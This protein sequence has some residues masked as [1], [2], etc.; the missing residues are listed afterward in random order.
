MENVLNVKNCKLIELTSIHDGYDGILCIAESSKH[1]PFDIKRVY[2]IYNLMNHQD[3]MRGKHAHKKLKQVL[4]CI[5]G[6]CAVELDDGKNKQK[7]ILDQPH[8][9]IYLGNNLWHTMSEFTNNCILL[10]MAS[11]VYDESDYIRDY[12]EFLNHISLS[13]AAV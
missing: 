6:S 1:I 4:F 8:Q 3:V 9:G 12:Q 2:Y 13:P 10:V 7:I 5:S 11:D